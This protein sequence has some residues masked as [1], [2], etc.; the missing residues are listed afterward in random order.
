MNGR[1]IE[2][3]E[4]VTLR[5]S[6]VEEWTDERYLG[7]GWF[8]FLK[9]GW[10]FDPLDPEARELSFETKG[11]ALATNVYPTSLDGEGAR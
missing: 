1:A 4:P 6:M 9:E 5:R 8:V 11:E 7:H 3:R 2:V 10:S